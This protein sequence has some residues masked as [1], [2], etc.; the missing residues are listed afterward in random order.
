[1]DHPPST[2]DHLLSSFGCDGQLLNLLFEGQTFLNLSSVPD[3]CVLCDL[4]AK[5]LRIVRV[6][7]AVAQ[8][9]QREEKPVDIW[10][11]LCRAMPFRGYSFPAASVKSTMSGGS[12]DAHASP[13]EGTASA[14]E[15]SA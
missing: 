1:M 10:L 11:R 9:L 15:C 2:I 4:C 14:V 13:I 3:L 5:S 6:R 7:K 8:R 12:G